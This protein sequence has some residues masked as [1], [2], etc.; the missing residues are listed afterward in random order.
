MLD[1]INFYPGDFIYNAND[2]RHHGFMLPPI[3]ADIETDLFGFC[4]E[5][6][7][8]RIYADSELIHADN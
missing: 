6:I 3:Y 4:G 1:S 8:Q 5:F 7:P 2:E